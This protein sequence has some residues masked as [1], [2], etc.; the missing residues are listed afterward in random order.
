MRAGG[1]HLHPA[2]SNAE[3]A[4]ERGEERLR[5]DLDGAALLGHERRV[6]GRHVRV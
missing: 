1:E 6:E 3:R 2:R 5:R 4:R